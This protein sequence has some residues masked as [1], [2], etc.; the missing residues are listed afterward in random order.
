L[1]HISINAVRLR[2]SF[3]RRRFRQTVCNPAGAKSGKGSLCSPGH[4]PVGQF[5]QQGIFFRQPGTTLGVAAGDAQFTPLHFDRTNRMTGDFRIRDFAQKCQFCFHPRFPDRIARWQSQLEAVKPNRGN[6]ATDESC[7]ILVRHGAEQPVF[8]F[9]PRPQ[10]S[11]P[12][13]K[14]TRIIFLLACV[15]LF[16]LNCAANL[17]ISS[18]ASGLGWM[19]IVIGV[20]LIVLAMLWAARRN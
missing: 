17:L 18:K 7:Q 2:E 16:F 20:A 6:P 10:K 11:R 4:L 1:H 12:R 9:R 3:G 8:I 5:A 15:A 13:K 19:F 14:P